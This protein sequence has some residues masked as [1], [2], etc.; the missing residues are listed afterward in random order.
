M[1]KLSVIVPIYNGESFI[2]KCLDSIINQTYTNIEIVIINDGSTDETEELCNIYVEK[3]NNIK[4]YNQNNQGLSQARNKGLE[5]SSGEYIGYVDIDDFIE[6]NMYAELIRLLE[7][8]NLDI[9]SCV[10]TDDDKFNNVY[11]NDNNLIIKD[12]KRAIIDNLLDIDCSPTAKVIKRHIL[13]KVKFPANM[14]YE[15]IATAYLHSAETNKSGFINAPFYHAI[16]RKDSLSRG[17]ITP[18][19]RHDYLIINK[20]RLKYVEENGY[21]EVRDYLIAKNIESALSL[22]TLLYSEKFD[23]FDDFYEEANRILCIYKNNVNAHNLLSIKYRLFLKS[24]VIHK[25]YAKLR[26]CIK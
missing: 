21:M 7:K 18:K 26:N 11:V 25:I 10:D 6:P 1:K 19:K 13:E 5:I 8:N 15:D 16:P 4:L 22:L 2:N 9:I 14:I 24:S 3:Y 17:N 23:G 12:R 20:Q